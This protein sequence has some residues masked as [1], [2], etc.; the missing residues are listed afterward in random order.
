MAADHHIPI[1]FLR[2]CFAVDE[3]YV[4]RWRDRP[5]HHFP[6]ER[7]WHSWNQRYPGREAGS[8]SNQGYRRINLKHAD[9]PY[10]VLTHRVIWAM[11]KN[12]WPTEID[13]YDGNKLNN[14]IGN[15]REVRH[16]ENGQNRIVRRGFSNMQ[17]KWHAQIRFK[18]KIISL[19]SY[20]TQEDARAAYLA[21]KRRYHK[22]RPI[23]REI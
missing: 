7:S 22:H 19:G 1:R 23:P 13:H 5:R 18:G 15:L 9:K 6:S 21:G 17:G 10:R 3:N 11:A 20:S 4:V 8:I 16:H 2:E 12:R 14:D